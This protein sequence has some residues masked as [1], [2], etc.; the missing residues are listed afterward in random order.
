MIKSL[1]VFLSVLGAASLNGSD[2]TADDLLTNTNEPTVESV[3]KVFN[4]FKMSVRDVDFTETQAKL[5]KNVSDSLKSSSN[6]PSYKLAKSKG[7][8]WRKD[9]VNWLEENEDI[10][11]A[12]SYFGESMG[13]IIEYCGFADTDE[14]LEILGGTEVTPNYMWNSIKSTSGTKKS[15]GYV[16]FI[17]LNFDAN[18]SNGETVF[19][20]YPY[21]SERLGAKLSSNM[22]VVSFDDGHKLTHLYKK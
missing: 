2:F 6:K 20:E 17:T 21:M 15:V 3:K 9:A 10:Y 16:L 11:E 4:Q 14:N 8:S 18:D 12:I 22:E 7:P 5:L 13:E 1:L 19:C